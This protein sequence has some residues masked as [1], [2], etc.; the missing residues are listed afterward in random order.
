MDVY[1]LKTEVALTAGC[2]GSEGDEY[3]II[4]VFSTADKA[5]KAFTFYLDHLEKAWREE[6]GNAILPANIFNRFSEPVDNIVHYAVCT[7]VGMD[8]SVIVSSHPLE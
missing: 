4:G 7:R 1:I 6:D 3:E 2:A 5:Q 8:Y